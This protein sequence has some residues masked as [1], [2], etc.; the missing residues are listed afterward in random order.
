MQGPLPDLRQR[1][2]LK[3]FAWFKNAIGI[4]DLKKE[5]KDDGSRCP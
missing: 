2:N 5:E 4:T 1:V 3:H